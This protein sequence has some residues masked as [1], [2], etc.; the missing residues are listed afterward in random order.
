M[1]S[2]K[3]NIAVF[4]VLILYVEWDIV[5][6]FIALRKKKVAEYGILTTYDLNY[7]GKPVAYYN[8]AEDIRIIYGL[9]V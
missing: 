1:V 5:A 8:C 2:D 7:Y 3:Q 6:T 9:Q 4:H